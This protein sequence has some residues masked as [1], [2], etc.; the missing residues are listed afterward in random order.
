MKKAVL[1]VA[2][3]L[4]ATSA[5]AAVT[6]VGSWTVD[7]GPS[8]TVVPPAYTGQEAAALLFGGP[9]SK[10][11]ISTIDANPETIDDLT[12][13]STWGGA[14]NDDFPC[15]TKV[16]ANFKVSSGGLY[17]DTGD[18]SA[19]VND[20]ALGPQ[21]VNYAFAAVPEAGTWAMLIAGFG[22]TGAVIRRRRS[23]IA[24]A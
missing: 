24:T 9:A 2:V 8:W 13:V 4:M 23:A 11:R 3:A 15:G 22:L 16:A 12:W 21:Y 18:T 6:F 7:S 20:W 19:Y 10:Y 17:L 14:C 1:A 5:N